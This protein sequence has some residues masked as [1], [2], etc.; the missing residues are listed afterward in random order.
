MDRI[1]VVIVIDGGIVDGS[2]LMFVL[3][4]ESASRKS[5]GEAD[6]DDGVGVCNC[7]DANGEG[8]LF[9]SWIL[10]NLGVVGND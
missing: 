5:M 9:E 1:V 2:R 10:L 6:N 7:G 3:R 4:V 8:L